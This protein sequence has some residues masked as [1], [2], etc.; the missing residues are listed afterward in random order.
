MK[1]LLLNEVI[2][3]LLDLK[4]SLLSPLMKLYYFGKETKNEEVITFLNKEIN[5]YSITDKVPA[6]REAAGQLEVTLQFGTD[7]DN[8]KQQL[9]PIS[10]FSKDHQEF[11]SRIQVHEG[12]G[13][14]EQMALDGRKLP[15]I[16]K[17]IPLEIVVHVIQPVVAKILMSYHRLTATEAIVKANANIVPQACQ[18]VRSKLI[19]FVTEIADRFGYE[20]EIKKFKEN[21][22]ENNRIINNYMNTITNTGDGNVINTG[23]HANVTATITITKGDVNALDKQLKEHGIDNDDIRELNEIIKNEE[24]DRENDKLG[25]KASTWIGKIIGKSVGG[26]GKI[27]TAVTANLLAGWIRG[28]Y[29]MP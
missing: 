3:E 6:Y 10:V 17:T 28:Y 27:A 13:I 19:D 23:D 15:Y 7:A 5:G 2:D 21:Q 12:I 1:N 14:L 4:Q 11:L 18:T 16:C 29:G 9:L 20:I 25:V 26:I 22:V 8:L 24:P